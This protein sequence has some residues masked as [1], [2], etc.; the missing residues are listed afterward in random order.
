M[1]LHIVPQEYTDEKRS[2]RGGTP[3]VS[4]GHPLIMQVVLGMF[5]LQLMLFSVSWTPYSLGAKGQRWAASGVKKHPSLKFGSEWAVPISPRPVRAK[6]EI[7]VRWGLVDSD[8]DRLEASDIKT[9]D[10]LADSVSATNFFS[11]SSIFVMVRTEVR[12]LLCYLVLYHPDWTLFKC[13]FGRF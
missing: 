5:T 13:S 12:I 4:V 2:Q 8:F 7:A 1:D 9:F 10:I 11:K 6:R 3:R